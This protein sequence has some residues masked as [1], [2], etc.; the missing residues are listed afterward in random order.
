MARGEEKWTKGDPAGRERQE[1]GEEEE[2][3][4]NKGAES[5]QLNINQLGQSWVK[6]EENK[7]ELKRINKLIKHLQVF[8]FSFPFLPLPPLSLSLCVPLTDSIH[9]PTFPQ[10]LLPPCLV[11]AS[12]A[13]LDHHLVH[14]ALGSVDE[15]LSQSRSSSTSL[16]R[17][18]HGGFRPRFRILTHYGAIATWTR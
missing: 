7:K 14:C 12:D 11:I 2:N 9:S 15:P 13:T 17:S 8:L 1:D 5:G 4:R 16:L 3:K 18:M 10:S 6:Q